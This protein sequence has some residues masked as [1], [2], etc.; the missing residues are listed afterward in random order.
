MDLNFEVTTIGSEYLKGRFC[1]DKIS[2]HLSIENLNLNA[3]C[4]GYAKDIHAHSIH[5]C[6]DCCYKLKDFNKTVAMNDEML[7]LVYQR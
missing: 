4:F 2:I 1:N 3:S 7:D 5:V 6:C